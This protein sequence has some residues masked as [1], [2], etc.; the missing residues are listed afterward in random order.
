MLDVGDADEDLAGA[1]RALSDVGAAFSIDRRDVCIDEGGGLAD[2]I[3]KSMRMRTWQML[4]PVGAGELAA[5][6][7]ART[8][9]APTRSAEWRS[10]RNSA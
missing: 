10:R 8:A 7:L 6:M 2:P 3:R 4:A 1:A 9:A 5:A